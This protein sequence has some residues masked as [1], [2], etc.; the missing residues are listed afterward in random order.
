MLPKSTL[1]IPLPAG[2]ASVNLPFAAP[3]GIGA[4]PTAVSVKW[5]RSL[6]IATVSF[7][8]AFVYVLF[9]TSFT[10]PGVGFV[11]VFVTVNS[12][13]CAFAFLL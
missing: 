7:V 2:T 11:Y 12:S 8:A 9:A 13:G 3:A 1:C 10:A 5:N 4:V 6:P